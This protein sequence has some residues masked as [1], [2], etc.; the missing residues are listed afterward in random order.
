VSVDGAGRDG[1]AVPHIVLLCTGNAARSVMAGAMLE[2]GGSPVRVTTAGTHVIENQP[3]SLRTRDALRA[4]GLHVSVHRSHQLTDDD[5]NGA[6]LLVAMAAEH[7]RYVRRRHP[8]GAGRTATVRWLARHLPAG[9][10]PL[11]RRVAGL[12]L[13]S[14]DPDQQGDVVDP[15]G[16]DEDDYVACVA[17]LASLMA[18]LGPRLA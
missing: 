8:A 10:G 14:I 5:V 2:A 11:V 3:V 18:E 16:G 9:P 12:G 17:E 1:A 6:D 4:V 13:E 15:A 7:V